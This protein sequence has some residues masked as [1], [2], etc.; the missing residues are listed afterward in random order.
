LIFSP[1]FGTV[2]QLPG[3][4]VQISSFNRISASNN[5][6]WVVYDRSRINSV[7]INTADPPPTSISVDAVLVPSFPESVISILVLG[8][9]FGV[10]ADAVTVFVGSTQFPVF[11]M[12]DGSILAY[13]HKSRLE[14]LLIRN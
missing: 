14:F 10:D 4:I 7:S 1:N 13:M 8:K 2:T 6:S 5:R 9:N 11:Q 3:I 12:N